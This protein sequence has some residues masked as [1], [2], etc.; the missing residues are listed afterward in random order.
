MMTKSNNVQIT[1]LTEMH[2][3][4]WHS[5]ILLS[6]IQTTITLESDISESE[7]IMTGQNHLDESQ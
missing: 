7:I 2:F 4:T 6:T 5:F 1:N 3:T